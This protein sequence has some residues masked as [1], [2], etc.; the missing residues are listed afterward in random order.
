[1]H[2]AHISIEKQTGLFLSKEL[3]GNLRR[4]EKTDG[5]LGYFYTLYLFEYRHRYR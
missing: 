2:V 4:V 5:N 3:E 1:M